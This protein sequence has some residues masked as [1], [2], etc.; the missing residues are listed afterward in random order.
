MK[1]WERGDTAV[2][3]ILLS[4]QAGSPLAAHRRCLQ[5]SVWLSGQGRISGAGGFI[6]DPQE[7]VWQESL[8]SE[9]AEDLPGTGQGV[10]CMHR[11]LRG[12]SL[13]L[14][15]F[16]IALLHLPRAAEQAAAGRRHTQ[17]VQGFCRNPTSAGRLGCGLQPFSGR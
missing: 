17:S 7:W 13:L 16:L 14:P 15:S 11:W 6:R 1:G 2:T 8:L 4:A 9:E 3:S 10:V 5:G 12:S